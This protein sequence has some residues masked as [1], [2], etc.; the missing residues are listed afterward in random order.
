MKR[1][2]EIDNKA[3]YFGALGHIYA[4]ADRRREAR[5][6][7]FSLD[8]RAKH[9]YV[10]PWCQAVIYAG[11]KDTDEAFGW[12]EKAYQQRSYCVFA[13]KVAAIFDSLHSDRRFRA[14]VHCLRL[15]Q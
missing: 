15:D 5:K 2:I 6:I 3:L 7:L 13:L 9:E 8:E 14:M 12:L 4:L 10:D 1:A 11:L